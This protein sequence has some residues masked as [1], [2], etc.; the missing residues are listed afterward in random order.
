MPFKTHPKERLAHRNA[1]RRCTNPK[2]KSF[3]NYGARGIKFNYPSFQAF[4]ADL[5]PCPLGYVL[6]RENNDGHYEAGN[7][8]WVTRTTSAEN[9]RNFNQ[10]QYKGVFK[11]SSGRYHAQIRHN[12]KRVCM[13]VV[14]TIEQAAI[15]F[16]SYVLAH[17]LQR[18]LNVVE[19]QET[20]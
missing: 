10:R 6:D 5:G 8:R 16:N 4:L 9:R 18:I 17:G 14:D 3:N 12:G 19:L 13:P 11:T 15:D 20:A 1:K 7:C 2:D